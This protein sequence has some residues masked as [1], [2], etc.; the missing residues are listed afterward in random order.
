MNAFRT[1]TKALFFSMFLF[2]FGLTASAQSNM[3]TITNYTGCDMDLGAVG[4]WNGVNCGTQQVTIQALN[5]AANGGSA[6]VSWVPIPGR[7]AVSANYVIAAVAHVNGGAGTDGSDA[8]STTPG[9]FCYPILGGMG[10][11][12]CPSFTVTIDN[13]AGTIDIN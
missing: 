3:I 6:T 4:N 11:P 13:A 5:L 7:G 8:A 10:T 9:P 2:A 1:I 12:S